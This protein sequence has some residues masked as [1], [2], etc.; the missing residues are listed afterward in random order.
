MRYG[1]QNSG[2]SGG[3]MYDVG[4]IAAWI[5]SRIGSSLQAKRMKFFIDLGADFRLED[6]ETY[7]TW[8]GCEFL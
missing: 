5:I 6:E 2:G 7:K 1:L 8:Y 4:S 3:K